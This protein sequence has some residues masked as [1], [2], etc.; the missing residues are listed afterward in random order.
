MKASLLRLA[1][2]EW[3]GLRRLKLMTAGRLIRFVFLG[4]CYA[5]GVSLTNQSNL[6]KRDV[7]MRNANHNLLLSNLLYLLA[8]GIQKRGL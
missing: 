4:T 8:H 7:F 2:I 3:I 1:A 6:R 5:L